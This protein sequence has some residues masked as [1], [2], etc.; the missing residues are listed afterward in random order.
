V[1]HAVRARDETAKRLEVV[2][3]PTRAEACAVADAVVESVV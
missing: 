3:E 1:A 2:R